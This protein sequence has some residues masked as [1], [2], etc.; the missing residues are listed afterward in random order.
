[1]NSDFEKSETGIETF[2]L[3]KDLKYPQEYDADFRTV[4][5]IS[6]ELNEKEINNPRVQSMFK[7]QQVISPFS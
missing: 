6:H 1:M 3:I 7:Q 2:G 4:V 5:N